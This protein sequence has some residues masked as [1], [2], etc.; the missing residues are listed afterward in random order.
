LLRKRAD[1]VVSIGLFLLLAWMVFD[2]QQWSLRAR[3]FPWTIGIPAVAL[4]ALQVVFATRN[5]LTAAPTEAEQAPS[6][7]ERPSP[8]PA[9]EQKDEDAAVVAAAVESAFGAGSAAAEE[10]AIP[11]AVTRRRTIEMS[12]WILGFGLGVVLLGFRLG[13]VLVTFGF[14]RWGAHESWKTTIIIAIATY[15]M[16]FLIF[17]V[18]LNTPF[19]PGF[20]ADALNVDA[21]DSVITDPIKRLITSR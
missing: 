8:L 14:L 1:L 7:I 9:V 12:L 16:F 18:G 2:A 3:L 4:A 11:P 5:M 17:D 10:E 15:L 21:F 19:P 6:P 20:I 13:A